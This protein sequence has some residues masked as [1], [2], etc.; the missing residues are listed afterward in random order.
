MKTK[1]TILI[2]IL[3]T[4]TLINLYAQTHVNG[5]VTNEQNNPIKGAIVTLK[6][7]HTGT[8]TDSTGFY[9][10][11]SVKDINQ[12][13]FSFPGMKTL[14]VQINDQKT[15]NVTMVLETI[16]EEND[17]GMNI[18]ISNMAIAPRSMHK[19][20]QV[21]G[22]AMMMVADQSYIN[23]NTED[24]SAIHESG[25]RDVITNP[26]STFSIDV[27]RASYANIR[28]FLNMGQ[29]PHKDAVRV[30][31]MIN[32]FE[33]NYPEP[34]NNEPINIITEYTTCPWNEKHNL[35][36]IG[37]QGKHI[38]TDRLPASNLVFLLDVSGSMNAANKLPLVKSS[39]KML[40]NNLRAQDK[41]AI[42]V[43]AGAAG[44]VL[45]STPGSNKQKI[46][47]ALDNLSAGGSTAGGA[48]IQLAYKIA[49]E[50]FIK[51]GNN[52]IILGTDGD[53]NVGQSSDAAMERMVEQ[54]R[55][56]GIFLTVLG[57]GMGNYKDNKLETIADKGNGNYAYIDNSQEAHK[58]FIKEFGGTLFTIAKD[59]KLQ[60]EFNPQIVKA[61]RLIGYENRALQ[62]EDFNNDK[63]DAGEL[64]AG[65]TVTA[66]YE[67]V[68]ANSDE[69]V[70]DVDDLKYQ[71][72]KAKKNGSHSNEVLTVK[73]RYKDPDENKSKLIQQELI[74]QKS[75]IVNASENLKFSSALV[76][77]GML[78]RNSEYKGNSDVENTLI[79]A[80]SGKSTD[81]EGY[82]AE[83]IRLIK[84]AQAL[85]L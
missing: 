56:N 6:G 80:N 62:N 77:F 43:Y 41:V 14:D 51:G 73:I 55:D 24:Y 25:Y 32:Y 39:M 37:L 71:K 82:R 47:E 59:V 22:T 46:I 23:H 26:L 8:R 35:V 28:R 27:D 85:G 20:K 10:L 16:L 2:L 69:K 63:I 40:V 48:G 21:S 72:I 7:M 58:V 11:K 67:I 42:V 12:L 44:V 76:Q 18:S 66:L 36:S 83:F 34:E 3:L 65:H 19:S 54:Q 49:S 84:T 53:F 50:N 33:Y 79:L 81:N 13:I 15:V 78:L 30:E 57:F 64:G 52:R 70:L 9:E 29:L 1:T 68:P 17:E 31:E 45:E 75:K 5:Y 74:E 61:Y 60:V 4:S 38:E